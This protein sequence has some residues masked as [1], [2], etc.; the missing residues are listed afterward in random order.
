MTQDMQHGVKVVVSP[1]HGVG[2]GIVGRREGESDAGPLES[3]LHHLEPEVGGIVCVNL[4][5]ITKPC[6][7]CL[8]SLQY[9]LAGGVAAGYGFEPLAEDVL[10]RDQVPVAFWTGT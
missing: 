8:K 3:L 7:K 2:L 1:F 10:Q 9:L 6:I 4:Q 5:G